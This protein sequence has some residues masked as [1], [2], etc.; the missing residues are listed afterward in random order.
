MVVT[1]ASGAL[2][3]QLPIFVHQLQHRLNGHPAAADLHL[4]ICLL[5]GLI[6]S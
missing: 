3:L 5:A 1:A 6:V 2:L 4:S